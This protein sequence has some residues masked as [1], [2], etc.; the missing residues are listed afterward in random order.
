MEAIIILFL[1]KSGAYY[2]AENYHILRIFLTAPK[3][4]FAA[5]ASC[6]PI[7]DGSI[8]TGW[9]DFAKYAE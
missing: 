8:I 9:A 1:Q 4:Y 6:G 2:R 3:A 7:S 5:T